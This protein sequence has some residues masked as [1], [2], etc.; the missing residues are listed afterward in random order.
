MRKAASLIVFL[1]CSLQVS[2]GAV[3]VK[4]VI[5]AQLL[6]GQNYYN[7]SASSFGGLASLTLSP[8]TQFNERWSLVP[9]YA[10]NYGGTKQVTD[11]VGGGTLFQDSQDHTFSTKLIRSFTNGLKLKAVGGYGLEWLRETKDESWTKGLYDNRRSF[12]GGEAEWSWDKDRYVR[13][14]YDYYRIRFPNYQSL[15][16]GQV[17]N[18]LGRELS[19]PNVL[20]NSNH[21]LTLGARVGLPGDGYA[22]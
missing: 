5:D 18:G 1:V 20:D 11:L 6:G 10:G 13:L 2:G 7:G 4:P 22:Y 14:A 21:A 15:E 12:G 9:L 16:S 8:Y 17:N 3:D 19:Q